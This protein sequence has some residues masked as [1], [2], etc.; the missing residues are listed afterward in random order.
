MSLLTRSLQENRRTLALAFPIAAGN[1]GQMLMG[2]ADTVMV[3][4]VGVVALAACAFA[5]TV[6]AVPLVFGFGF[7]SGVSVR[8][9]HAFGADKPDSAGQALKWGAV[10]ALATGILVALL[11]QCGVPLLPLLGQSPEVNRACVTFLLLCAWSVIPVYLTSAAKSYAEALGHPWEPFWIMMGGV[12]LN[13]FLNWVFIY[14]NLGAPALGLEGAG[15]ATLISRIVT[16]L[17]VVTFILSSQ[18]FARYRPHNPFDFR[19]RAE[20]RSLIKIGLPAGTMHLAEVGGFSFGSVMMGWAGVVPLAAHQIA[21]TCAATVFM[22]PLGVS[23]AVAV[24]I[25]QARGAKAS[26]RFL[27]IAIGA[28]SVVVSLMFLST[29]VFVLGGHW[30]ARAFVSDPAVVALTTKLLL[31]AGI[32]QIVD[33]IQIVCSGALRGFE[34][35]RVPMFIG[36]FSY[37]AVALPISYFLAFHTGIGPAGVWIG[38]VVGL[39]VAAVSLVWRLWLRIATAS[40]TSK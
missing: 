37:W 35:T 18:E 13:I 4:Q 40:R 8:T 16:M 21:I 39:W 14:G 7:L 36:I 11:I 3:G 27:P 17:G 10:L 38:F 22:I 1:A 29:L 26:E 9:S 2:V 25:G 19:D 28:Q 15:V 12:L 23:Q 24:R 6:L 33:G 34:D 32:F 5:N 31:L 30:I 20:I